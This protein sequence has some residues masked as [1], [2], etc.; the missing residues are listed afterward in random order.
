MSQETNSHNKHL[1]VLDLDKY[2]FDDQGF[3]DRWQTEV[4]EQLTYQFEKARQ[5]SVQYRDKINQS[6]EKFVTSAAHNTVLVDGDRGTGKSYFLSNIEVAWHDSQQVKENSNVKTRLHFCRVIDP[7]L[8]NHHDNFS[9]VVIAHL[10]NEVREQQQQ[11]YLNEDFNR[12]LRD[13][14]EALEATDGVSPPAGIDR[15][16]GYRSAV[17]IELRF[18]RF[19]AACLQELGVDMLVLPI[20]DV[21][22]ELS[23]AH[24][25]LEEIR[26]LLSCPMILPVVSGNIELFQELMISHFYRGAGGSKGD[27]KESVALQLAKDY[28]IKVFPVDARMS[29]RDI[30]LFCDDLIIKQDGLPDMGFLQYQQKLNLATFPYTKCHWNINTHN[31]KSARLLVQQINYLPPNVINNTLK[32]Y[33]EYS[34]GYK[35]D[36]WY[37]ASKSFKYS[38]MAMVYI[39]A[40]GELRMDRARSYQSNLPNRINFQLSDLPIFNPSLQKLEKN[41]WM[42]HTFKNLNSEKLYR[43]FNPFPP[44]VSYNHQAYISGAAKKDCTEDFLSIFTSQ[45]IYDRSSK[46]RSYICFGRAFEILIVSLLFSFRAG[47]QSKLM[48]WLD[49]VA[50]REHF[51]SIT[52]PLNYE[53]SD[54]DER[55]H[56]ES[57]SRFENLAKELIRWED[58]HSDIL[59]KVRASGVV[60]ICS[61]V[62]YHA[63]KELELLET[64]KV[65]EFSTLKSYL[66]RFEIIIVNAFGVS[67]S[68]KP[69]HSNVGLNPDY[70]QYDNQAVESQI[71][72]AK[73]VIKIT[74]RYELKDGN[75][76][77]NS[78]IPLSDEVLLMRCIWNH[79]IFNYS[80]NFKP[81]IK[82][83]SSSSNSSSKESREEDITHRK[84]IQFQKMLSA[85]NREFINI[86]L[87]RF[88]SR[89]FGL[90]GVILDTNGIKDFHANAK[91]FLSSYNPN[92][93]PTPK[94]SGALVSLNATTNSSLDV[95][96]NLNTA[97]KHYFDCT[98]L[99]FYGASKLFK[100]FCEL[101]YQAMCEEEANA[102]SAN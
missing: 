62:H 9:N 78:V 19:I 10:Y 52:N 46:L 86:N 96:K 12:T 97:I 93:N 100:N 39:I 7:T 51:H 30:N 80:I 65:R 13:L 99:E 90:A 2:E 31:F 70:L 89:H 92:P 53:R 3:D 91:K 59:N 32:E 29:L 37:L 5:Q 64:L 73:N 77:F 57:S 22:M 42:K 56:N 15:I 101:A 25:V 21:D 81:S 14:A 68:E 85:K 47:D 27:L 20:D 76:E 55:R 88:L 6:R 84:F 4:E 95:L 43:T 41:D 8:L 60:G 54:L 17:D 63:F 98:A 40:D 94:P 35:S 36:F 16:I 50:Q 83:G 79:P 49:D 74:G 67:L 23:R 24:E 82:L 102:N 11:N 75:K 18:H 87:Y 44:Q 33:K 58:Q 26:R 28:L 69:L 61:F 45:H 66:K 71:I 34:L 1:K 48:R 72:M 38:D